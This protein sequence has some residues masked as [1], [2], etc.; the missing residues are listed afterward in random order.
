[1]AR[2]NHWTSSLL[3]P[4]GSRAQNRQSGEQILS[5]HKPGNC[6]QLAQLLQC[7]GQIRQ[8]AHLL[9]ETVLRRACSPCT[10]LCGRSKLLCS[11]FSGVVFLLQ[12]SSPALGRALPDNHR[13]VRVLC[14][15]YQIEGLES[16]A[17]SSASI[18]LY[19]ETLRHFRGAAVGSGDG[20]AVGSGI[21]VGSSAARQTK[22]SF[23]LARN[24]AATAACLVFNS[25]ETRIGCGDHTAQLSVQEE[26]GV[27]AAC[28]GR[29]PRILALDSQGV[30]HG[31]KL[32]RYLLVSLEGSPLGLTHALGSRRGRW[33][34]ARALRR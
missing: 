33:R 25:A 19:E 22:Q 6:V 34:A 9:L 1:M 30:R 20:A 26:W 12:L 7:I 23:L 18:T 10:L 15:R 21:V 5:Q 28:A 13:S 2:F 3:V 14:A 8:A 17:G 4:V 27:G 31:V 11:S 29:R 16:D 32:C 24:N